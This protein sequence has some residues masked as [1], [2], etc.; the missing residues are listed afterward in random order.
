[1][2]SLSHP[3]HKQIQHVTIAARQ[4]EVKASRA[5]VIEQFQQVQAQFDAQLSTVKQSTGHARSSNLAAKEIHDAAKSMTSPVRLE[6][7]LQ[8]VR[9]RSMLKMKALSAFGVSRATL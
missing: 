5:Q 8:R 4:F 2:Q 1:M 3:Q 9:S 7:I 6:R